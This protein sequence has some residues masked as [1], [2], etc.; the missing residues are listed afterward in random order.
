MLSNWNTSS[1]LVICSS[2][3]NW[4]IECFV[5]N[6][7][8]YGSRR[9]PSCLR[10]LNKQTIDD[11]FPWLV[12]GFPCNHHRNWLHCTMSRGGGVLTKHDQCVGHPFRK[13][14]PPSVS[15]CVCNAYGQLSRSPLS[16]TPAVI[17]GNILGHKHYSYR[18]LVDVHLAI[19]ITINVSG[20]SQTNINN[21]KNI[22]P[23]GQTLT[24]GAK[25]IGKLHW[26]GTVPKHNSLPSFVHS[27][28]IVRFNL[29]SCQIE[30]SSCSSF[31]ERQSETTTAQ[32]CMG[33]SV[34]ACYVT[35]NRGG[36]IR[37]NSVWFDEYDATSMCSTRDADQTGI[38]QR[39]C[40]LTTTNST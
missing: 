37:V 7:S 10:L 27:G 11:L 31:W 26:V 14:I 36:R 20:A 16:L 28:G 15:E 33:K 22:K 32:V 9:F 29:N 18:W 39:N 4:F 34:C 13:H 25:T 38:E 6:L 19:S 5:E 23:Q 8:D 30:L 3:Q 17:Y 24:F 12:E 40:W 21:N 35:P 2:K 1:C